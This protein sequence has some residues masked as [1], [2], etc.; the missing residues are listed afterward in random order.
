MLSTDLKVDLMYAELEMV[1]KALKYDWGTGVPYTI[2]P[3]EGSI[4][5]TALPMLAHLV[6]GGP[7]DPFY[8]GEYAT[9]QHVLTKAGSVINTAF[10]GANQSH[11]LSVD[12]YFPAG[13]FTD[14]RFRYTVPPASLIMYPYDTK[15][16]VEDLKLGSKAK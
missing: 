1:L 14:V 16:F 8:Q 12:T 10:T 7:S 2:S 9:F 6:D 11:V 13:R 15:V 5:I 4:T 3:T